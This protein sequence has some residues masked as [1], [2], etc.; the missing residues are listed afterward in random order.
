MPSNKP[1]QLDKLLALLADGRWHPT[2]ELI[3]QVGHR[4]S[5]AIQTARQRGHTI[6]RR[7]DGI[8]NE[9]RLA[10][11]TKTHPDRS[12]EAINQEKICE[13]VRGTL[14]NLER[15]G[16]SWAEVLRA[17]SMIATQNG[18]S[19]KAAVLSDAARKLE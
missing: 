7:R 3:E 4:F 9:W 12:P 6:E 18:W 11:I 13:K 8:S 1:T 17:M 16:I 15:Q 19:D 5:V 2:E 10:P 14:N